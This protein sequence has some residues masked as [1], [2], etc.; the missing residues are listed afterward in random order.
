[1]ML[2]KKIKY[3]LLIPLI[4]IFIQCEPDHETVDISRVSELPKFEYNGGQFVSFLKGAIPTYEDPGVVAKVGEN[5]VRV[6]SYSPEDIRGDEA[7]VYV[8]FYFAQNDDG[9]IAEGRRIIAFTHEDVS[10]ND[11][12][13]KYVTSTSYGWPPVEAKVKKLN[14]RGWYSCTEVLGFPDVETKGEFVDIGRGELYLLPG[15]S[16]FGD[17][18]LS[19]GRHT[20]T[21]LSWS[22][23][24]LDDPYSG[25]EIPVVLIKSED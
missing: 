13:G 14:N 6:V 16:F 19:E 24:L 9:I 21:S 17:Y 3:I 22:I 5:E 12:S 25:I 11:L 20:F 10:L 18:D 23:Y 2:M 4:I 7:T 8:I 1:M 15:E